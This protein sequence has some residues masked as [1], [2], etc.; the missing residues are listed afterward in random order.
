MATK[1]PWEKYADQ[2]LAAQS[3]ATQATGPWQK[4]SEK[5]QQSGSLMD[6]LE[7]GA[8]FG[9]A[10]EAGAAG[11]ASGAFLK[12]L[13]STGDLKQASDA[14]GEAYNRRLAEIREGVSNYRSEHPVLGI[15][16][17][18]VGGLAGAGNLAKQGASL[19]NATRATAPALAVRGAAEG[20]AYGGAYGFG[21]GEGGFTERLGNAGGSAALGGLTG[22]VL[23]GAVGAFLNRSSRAAGPTT[24]DLRKAADEAYGA[25][26]GAGL[27]VSQPRMSAAVDE[28][29]S[30]AKSSGID[31]T[32]HPRATA[33]LKRLEEAAGTTP[34]LKDLELLRRILKG[35]AASPEPD[36]RRIAN[37]LIDKF[38]DVVNGLK[39]SD[40]QAGDI[41][42]A[43][44]ELN[45]ARDLWSRMRKTELIEGVVMKAK[46]R[47]ASTGSGGN[48]DN[49]LRQNIRA[50]LDNPR[51]IRGFTSEER[52][53]ME[54]VVKGGPIQ[55]VLRL[56]GKLSPHGNGLMAALGIGGTAV[57]PALAIVPAVGA[58]AKFVADRGTPA[59]IQALLSATR[60][61]GIPTPG[62]NI[63][64]AQRALLEAMIVGGA[65]QG[66]NAVSP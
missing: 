47:A 15:G 59:K 22:G 54:A 7:Q 6:M 56:L 57:N 60:Q 45:K 27:V 25:A 2:S 48:I 10:D 43:T 8:T 65:Q 12:A 37:I 26:D 16:A 55:N 34:S 36:E 33:A 44:S 42:T 4:Y 3:S 53:L 41:L 49:A 24:N 61:G 66:A 9:F 39:P 63:S 40:I 19:L 31:R 52:A 14:A 64:E 32:I 58:A 29:L 11:A 18:V 28:L 5:P 46:R 21:T 62:A 23:G 50:L 30:V 35:A 20:A 38:D 51:R 13:T 17:E 1:R